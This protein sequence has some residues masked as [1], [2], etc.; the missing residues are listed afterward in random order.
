MVNQ[1]AAQL[2]ETLKKGKDKETSIKPY[3]VKNH[4]FIVAKLLINNPSFDAQTKEKLVTASKNFGFKLALS[5]STIKQVGKLGVADAVLAFS[6]FKDKQSLERKTRR[7]GKIFVE[8]L[9]DALNAGKPNSQCT[10][11]L[12]EGDSAKGLAVA[13]ISEVGRENYGIYPLRG[14][15]MNIRK[16]SMRKI[17]ENTEIGHLIKIIGLE[18]GKKY[19]T[20]EALE[21]LR[22]K[23]VNVFSD[24]DLDG[25]H[26]AGLLVNFVHAQWPSIFKTKPNF[27]E[28]F[29]TPIMKLKSKRNKN[30]EKTFFTLHEYQEW[31]KKNKN[32]LKNWSIKYLKGLGSSSNQ[33]AKRYFKD[34]NKHTVDFVME[35]K[36]DGESI[37]LAFDP[38]KADER[39]SW[40]LKYDSSSFVDYSVDE[41]SLRKFFDN[42]FI[43]FSNYD[44]IRSIPCVIDG[45]K[46]TQRKVLYGMLKSNQVSEVKVSQVVGRIA[47]MT[48]Y[49][50]G[51][52]SL[53]ETICGMAQDHLGTN[54]VNYL[55]PEG[56]FGCRLAKPSVHAQPRY[57]FTCLDKIARYLFREEDDAILDH[58]E[59]E[60]KTIE[61][62]TYYPILPTRIIR[63]DTDTKFILMPYYIGFQ[64]EISRN[65]ED[66]ITIS[67]VHRVATRDRVEI[68][69]LPVGRWTDDFITEIS[70]KFSIQTAVDRADWMLFI[71]GTDNLSTESKV[72]IVLHCDDYKLARIENREGGVA[73]LLRLTS[74]IRTGNMWMFE[75]GS[76]LKKFDDTDQILRYFY[77]KRIVMYE[78]RKNYQIDAL[79]HKIKTSKNQYRF[80]ESVM[81]G[82]LKLFNR[83]D[84]ELEKD[85]IDLKL[86]KMGEPKTYEYLLKMPFV[87]A[88][89][90]KLKRLKKS[91]QE[92][93][94]TLTKLKATAITDLWLRDLKEFRKAYLEF[95]NRRCEK[96]GYTMLPDGARPPPLKP[97]SRKLE[98]PSSKSLS[99]K[100][101]KATSKR[102]STGARQMST[103]S[104]A[105]TGKTSR[106]RISKASSHISSRA[107]SASRYR[108]ATVTRSFGSASISR[109][110]SRKR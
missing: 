54:N 12:T 69:E 32:D 18:F 29:A 110:S 36:K 73:K 21:S 51:E 20:P 9:D 47:E 78:K 16:A 64:G 90:E 56:Q 68:L 63:G 53:V 50:H 102:R 11:I 100:K 17:G 13:G 77:K 60:G 85:M 46:P 59:D 39:K 58:V 108:S 14:K 45:L 41:I 83:E 3:M 48:N 42:E 75:P 33:D 94:D 31:E 22:Y 2:I 86:D 52:A 15:P 49:H 37:V 99:Q 1:V 57:I 19:D 4:L 8:K 26:I 109:S 34:L 92:S 103:R 89:K 44:N 23:K 62:I 67:G 71:K 104:R 38:D 76:S 70:R 88:T 35:D 95:L 7:G 74:T 27:I 87:S 55:M 107:S 82:K 105:V 81:E 93:E 40:L 91:I 72:K 84:K 10:L 28:R 6:K 30:V 96:Y 5:D 65:D 79:Q 43:H 106:M 25:H 98:K 80:I 61:P 101:S 97:T 66:V 24:Q